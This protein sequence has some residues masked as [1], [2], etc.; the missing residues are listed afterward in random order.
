MT[1]DIQFWSHRAQLFSEWEMFH[2]KVVQKIKTHILCSVTVFFFFENRAV[3]EIMWEKYCR[4][5]GRPQMAIWRMRNA[6][7]KPKA[8]NTHS[9]Y[10]ILIVFY[11]ATVVVR[12]SLSVTLH[13]HCLSGEFTVH[14]ESRPKRFVRIQWG[15]NETAMRRAGSIHK[16]YCWGHVP[17]GE[18]LEQC[19]YCR[20]SVFV[21]FV[22]IWE[23]TA[24][25]SLY[26]INWLVFITE[27]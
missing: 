2:T 10:V 1:T 17:T 8:T 7:P 19:T 16:Y 24:I 6:R 12:T 18:T 26:S 11:T 22:C 5:G 25:I 21:C 9:E 13:V 15:C 14:F 27:I 3:Y 4:A 23:Q 20:Q